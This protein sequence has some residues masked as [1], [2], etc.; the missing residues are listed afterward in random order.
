MIEYEKQISI[1]MVQQIFMLF[2]KLCSEY[3]DI[4]S[5]NAT[6]RLPRRSRPPTV[7][8]I[9]HGLSSVMMATDAFS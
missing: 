2:N 9:S 6:V 7:S 3:S 1:Y 5:Y 4:P 8:V